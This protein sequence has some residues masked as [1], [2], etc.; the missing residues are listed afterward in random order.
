MIGSNGTAPGELRDPYG[1]AIDSAGDLYVGEYYNYRVQNFSPDGRFLGKLIGADFPSQSTET[2]GRCAGNWLLPCSIFADPK[3]RVYV[4]H[5]AAELLEQTISIFSSSG[6]LFRHYPE[7]LLGYGG[8]TDTHFGASPVYSAAVAVD[9]KGHIWAA[10]V[11]EPVRFDPSKPRYEW[12]H[13]KQGVRIFKLARNGKELLSFGKYGRA[14]GELGQPK[15]E[16]I[17][18]A[19]LAI[20]KADNIWV[21]DPGDNRVQRFDA[22]VRYLSHIGPRVG[23]SGALRQPWGVAVGKHG[24]IYV[25]DATRIWMFDAAGELVALCAY[26]SDRPPVIDAM[27]TWPYRGLVVDA[28]G[29]IYVTDGT[30]DSVRKF[31]PKRPAGGSVPLD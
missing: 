14:S 7:L 13:E 10:I 11:Q 20:D 30:T 5:T 12:E 28:D 17:G 6:K 24:N 23:P 8:Y 1:L 15:V 31:V 18:T 19:L 21:V 2:H 9:S 27:D 16:G 29:N 22:N 25:A 3:G 26:L 4:T